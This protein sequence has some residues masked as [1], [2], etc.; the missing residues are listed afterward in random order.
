[1]MKDYYDS[2]ITLI[3]KDNIPPLIQ[4]IQKFISPV[5]PKEFDQGMTSVM[6]F[7]LPFITGMSQPKE[8]PL[9]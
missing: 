7:F 6:T 1:M 9:T 3:S 2:S 5:S 8:D 4:K